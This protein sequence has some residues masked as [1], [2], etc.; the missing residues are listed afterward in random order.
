VISRTRRVGGGEDA[1]EHGRGGRIRA[2][3]EQLAERPAVVV[4]TEPMD[5][6]PGWTGLAS[7]E[8]VHVDGALGLDRRQVLDHPPTRP[9]SLTELEGRAAAAQ[10]A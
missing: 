1:L 3:S 8:L 9:L 6:D 4:A 2:A 5:D 7:G 10:R